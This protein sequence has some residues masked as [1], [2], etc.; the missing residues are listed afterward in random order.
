MALRE[1]VVEHA[2]T[3]ARLR[4][5]LGA[6]RPFRP[7]LSSF[8]HDRGGLECREQVLGLRFHRYRERS[9]RDSFSQPAGKLTGCARRSEEVNRDVVC[10][11]RMTICCPVQNSTRSPA[12]I[13]SFRD[14]AIAAE[15]QLSL[16]FHLAKFRGGS[17]QAQR[18]ERRW[19]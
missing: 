1:Q 13:R 15:I 8:P 2:H 14:A 11:V 16:G 18:I 12:S 9:C 10:V 6:R 4:S 7:L 17:V 3:R 5:T 19:S